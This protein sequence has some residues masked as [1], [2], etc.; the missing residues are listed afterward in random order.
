MQS[1]YRRWRPAFRSRLTGVTGL[2]VGLSLL[3]VLLNIGCAK[4]RPPDSEISALRVVQNLVQAEPAE[5]FSSANFYSTKSKIKWSFEEQEDLEDWRI[6]SAGQRVSESGRLELEPESKLLR[7]TRDVDFE[8]AAVGVI[9]IDTKGLEQGDAFVFWTKGKTRF[10]ERRRVKAST[11]EEGKLKFVLRGHP[12]WAGRISQLRFDF[13]TPAEV[14][15]VGAIDALEVIPMEEEMARAREVPWKVDL[16]GE[17]REALWAPGEAPWHWTT[18]VPPGT[19]ELAFAYGVQEPFSSATFS[20]QIANESTVREVFRAVV[21]D[22][23]GAESPNRW[24]EAAI[25]LSNFADKTVRVEFSTALSSDTTFGKPAF[26]AE[27]RI[28]IGGRDERPNIVLISVDTLRADHL[29]LYGYPKQTS[30]FLDEW[31]RR[32]AVT[33]ENVVAPSPWTLPSHVTM[34]TGLDSLAHGHNYQDPVPSHMPLLAQ[35]LRAEGYKTIAIT[36][37]GFLHPRYGLARGFNSYKYWSVEVGTGKDSELEDGIQSVLEWLRRGPDSPF[38]LFFHTYAVHSPYRPTRPATEEEM[39]DSDEVFAISTTSDPKGPGEGF[40][41]PKKMIRADDK[42]DLSG[43]FFPLAIDLYDTGITRADAQIGR[44]LQVLENSKSLNDTIVV[45][46]SDHGEALGEKGLAGHA[47]LYDFNIL[48]PLVISAP[49]LAAVGKTVPNQVR[50]SD[51]TPTILDLASLSIPP[52]TSGVSLVPMLSETKQ[53]WRPLPAWSYAASGNFGLALR[54]PDGLKLIFQNSG[55]EPIAGQMEL[56]DLG[57]DP[58]ETKN[59]AYKEPDAARLTQQMIAHY[60][61]EIPALRLR[62]S[63]PDPAHGFTAQIQ[64]SLVGPH[65]VKTFD[66]TPP[67]IWDEGRAVVTVPPGADFTLFLEGPSYQPVGLV[68]HDLDS[69]ASLDRTLELED[70]SIPWQSEIQNGVWKQT[71]SPNLALPF[72]GVRLWWYGDASLSNETVEPTDDDLEEQ[73]RILGYIE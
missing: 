11:A 39:S 64:G 59:L 33:F 27:P 24:H 69:G 19:S 4:T 63:N 25:D 72:K 23:E 30:P 17:I 50:L 46:T 8:A 44:L 65:R 21:A 51:V 68:L 36:G 43:D 18:S 58:E 34:F 67:L 53:S 54:Q 73:L 35:R 41:V 52:D 20:I 40:R 57:V 70:V 15:Y 47:Y 13:W 31:A 1:D 3:S 12:R 22:K 62:L 29:S 6:R 42:S 7:M 16:G 38:F 9:E 60:S 28:R 26:W 56:F 2:S 55:W 61:T 32:K 45:F 14:F 5:Y 10:S 66:S 71:L 48:V 49:D 37:G